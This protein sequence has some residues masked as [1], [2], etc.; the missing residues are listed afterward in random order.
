MAN[1][2]ANGDV[3]I[4]IM[5]EV[6]KAKAS[7][8]AVRKEVS[9]MAKPNVRSYERIARAQKIV[10]DETVRLNRVTTGLAGQFKKNEG[11]F[12]G[13]A[14]S[15]MF[16]G[17]AMQQVF[18]GIWKSAS[19]TFNDVMHSVSGTI[20]SFDLLNG[21]VTYLQ[22]S[23]GAALEPVAALL[24]PIIDSITEWVQKNEEL[25]AGI[26]KWGFIIGSVLFM[27]G[28]LT[29]A[30]NGVWTMVK[31]VTTALKFLQAN[32]LVA[33]A[34]AA[35]LVV[36]WLIKIKNEVGGWGNFF[37]AVLRAIVRLF[38]LTVAAIAGLFAEA[39]AVVKMGWNSVV[40]F[41][42]D[43]I[44]TAIGWVNM[45]IRAI[46][47][48]TGSKIGLLP[49]VDVSG[50]LLDVGQFGDAFMDTYGSIMEWYFAKEAQWMPIN[51]TDLSGTAASLAGTTTTPGATGS[52][53]ATQITNFNTITIEGSG[54]T[55]DEIIAGYEQ[56][57]N[58]TA[59]AATGG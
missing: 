6:E 43:G 24:I 42:G 35:I 40:T 22:Y 17:M 23:I 44:N 46:N 13:W 54:M 51:S 53:G 14:L 55:V 5:A 7:L 30:F 25:V 18:S 33:M 2:S 12:Q 52:G 27:V 31:N 57:V 32:P 59:P 47:R 36:T 10:Q 19:T 4:R 3:I 8:K 50:A 26:V 48:I 28:F 41:I 20:T 15:V 49:E 56:R 11:R 45:L 29:L 16:F 39:W 37:T 58:S 38:M 34:V 21:S 9:N 1:S